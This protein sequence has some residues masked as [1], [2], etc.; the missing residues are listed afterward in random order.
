MKP[1]AIVVHFELFEHLILGLCAGFKPF[2]M[3]RFDF[4]AVVPAFHG[5]IVITVAFFAHA[6]NQLVFTEKFLVSH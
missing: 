1:F 5:G 4:K 2:A 6:T 3:N